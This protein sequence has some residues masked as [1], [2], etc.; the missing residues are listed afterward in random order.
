MKHLIDLDQCIHKAIEYNDNC[1]KVA[2]GIGSQ[3][4]ESTGRVL[5]HIDEIIQGVTKRMQQMYGPPRVAKRQVD[6]PYI[7]G[8]CGKNHPTGHCAPKNQ[9]MVRQEPQQ[10]L[11]CNFHKRWGNHSI[12]NCFNRIQHI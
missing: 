10:A 4:N 2:S 3:T 5:S 6:W 7:C 8:I 11:W 9:G 12:E 1:T